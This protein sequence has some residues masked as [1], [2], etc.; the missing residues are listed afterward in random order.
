MRKLREVRKYYNLR[1]IV[2]TTCDLCGKNT[3][4][5]GW[6]APPSIP[7]KGYYIE[8]KV[9]LT[10]CSIPDS[11]GDDPDPEV[12]FHICPDCFNSK[13]APWIMENGGKYRDETQ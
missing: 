3:P 12:E 8:T 9:A 11:Y 10:H 2:Y 6:S 7:S 13:L 4:G 1:E 5:E